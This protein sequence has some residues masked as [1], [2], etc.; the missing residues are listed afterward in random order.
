MSK[1]LTYADA[2][3]D[4][5]L[6]KTA[7]IA[8]KSLEET[9]R[10]SANGEVLQL[11]Y[12]NIFPHREGYLDL[13]VEGVGTKVLLAQLADKFDTIGVDAVAMAVNDTIRSGA[14]PLAIVDNIHTQRS[15]PTLV[16]ELFKGFVTG[17]TEAQCI[18]A[19]GEIGD[20]ADIIKGTGANKGFD[21]IVACI[22]EVAKENVIHGNSITPGDVVIGLRSTG[23]QSNGITLVRR[24]L[25]K[26]WGGR[27]DPFDV[28][29][30]LD[31]ELIYEALEPTKIYVKALADLSK[32]QSVKG[33]VH[34][35]GDAYLKFNRLMQFSPGI[36]FTFHNFKPQPIFDLVRETAE[37]VEKIE[38]TEMF[39]TFN[40]GWGFAIV[41]DKA[42]ADNVLGI[43]EKSGTESEVIG[44]ATQRK[45]IV[46][47]FRGETLVL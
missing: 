23:L 20:V 9:Y 1:G 24:T 28:P 43:L 47:K 3:V 29:E 17:A 16:K 46:V 32:T 42:N 7:K 33:A 30:C 34:I 31:R 5:E 38:W 6:R 26:E 25:F 37:A 10:F 45:E 40:M 2:G 19:G 36:G 39:K 12:G 35:T 8:L 22:G 4:R 21:L 11:P 44:E 14:T 15:D 13:A 18:I 41:V 27:F